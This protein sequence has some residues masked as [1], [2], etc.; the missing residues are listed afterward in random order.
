[1]PAYDYRCK[2]CDTAFS[3]FYKTYKA[4]DTAAKTCPQC[5]S[6]DLAR[7]ITKIN[8]AAPSRDYKEL[9]S[10]EMLSVLD[11][12]DGRAVGQMFQQIGGNAPELGAEYHYATQKLLAGQSMEKVERDLS[13]RKQDGAEA[14]APAATPTPAAPPA[15]PPQS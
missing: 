4:Y 14:A 11:S 6:A 1:M 15:P 3:L 13:A 2:N 10:K 5:A 8:V 7:V 9:S 12:G